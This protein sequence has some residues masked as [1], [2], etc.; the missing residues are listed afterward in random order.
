MNKTAQKAVAQIIDRHYYEKFQGCGLPIR[1]VGV[2]F[3]SSKG[4][5]NAWQEKKLQHK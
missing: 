1:L 3:N 4:Q 2:N 5:I